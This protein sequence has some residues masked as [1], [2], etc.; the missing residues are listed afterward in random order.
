MDRKCRPS[1]RVRSKTYGRFG[2]G[3]ASGAESVTKEGR[4]GKKKKKKE[5]G[6]KRQCGSDTQLLGNQ[7]NETGARQTCE[8]AVE[9][10]PVGRPWRTGGRKQ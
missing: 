3:S 5:I 7:T 10:Q 1:A 4:G 8:R 6:N 2:C 9:M